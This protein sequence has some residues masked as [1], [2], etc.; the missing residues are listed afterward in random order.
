[1]SLTRSTSVICCGCRHVTEKNIFHPVCHQE[2]SLS[3]TEQFY[4]MEHE[5]PALH[6]TDHDRLS[7]CSAKPEMKLY[8]SSD[9]SIR[10]TF[11][12]RLLG[13][14]WSAQSQKQNNGVFSSHPKVNTIAA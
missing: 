10:E 2:R 5:R 7:R 13:V 11:F 14:H 8:K 1:M 3:T 6:L 12:L 4:M 9:I